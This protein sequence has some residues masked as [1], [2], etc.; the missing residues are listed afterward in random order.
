[1]IK[2]PCSKCDNHKSIFPNCLKKCNIISNLQ[3]QYNSKPQ[4]SKIINSP[5][6]TDFDSFQVISTHRRREMI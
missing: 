5:N 4:H 6:Y 1:M 2:S 3:I